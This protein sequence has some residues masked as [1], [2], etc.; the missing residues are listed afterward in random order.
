MSNAIFPDINPGSNGWLYKLPMNVTPQFRTLVQRPANNRGVLRISTTPFPIFTFNLELPYIFGRPTDINNGYQQII[1]FYGQMLGQ[2]D[3]WL[4]SW[5]G[6]NT[7]VTPNVFGI[8]DGLTKQFFLT[9]KVGGMLEL[10]QNFVTDSPVI[11][12]GGSVVNTWSIDQ[13]GL[14][15]FATAPSIGLQLAWSG[16]FY[17]RCR[18]LEDSLQDLQL[19]RAGDGQPDMWNLKS[20]KFES[21]LL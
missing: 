21:I 13:S 2:A 18:F 10:I 9:K 6:N 17:Y 7:I 3:D 16:S 20:L 15:T 11:Y 4:F 8:G 19:I 12:V 1:G 14:L 5:P